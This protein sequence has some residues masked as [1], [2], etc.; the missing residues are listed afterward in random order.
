MEKCIH[1]EILSVW[2]FNNCILFTN[3]INHTHL[4]LEGLS[5]ILQS[6]HKI[7][8]HRA[9][10]YNLISSLRYSS[11]YLIR[12]KQQQ[13]LHILICVFARNVPLPVPADF[14]PHFRMW[15]A[16]SRSQRENTQLSLEI[17]SNRNFWIF[18]TNSITI[19][20]NVYDC[21]VTCKCG[22]WIET[23]Y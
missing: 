11:T 20:Y 5:H 2:I 16:A 19:I 14:L 3:K 9:T 8:F 18:L 12:L 7:G 22:K 13:C 21:S 10:K 1:H 6:T 17:N 15:N 23:L 4:T